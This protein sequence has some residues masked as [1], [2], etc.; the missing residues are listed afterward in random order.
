LGVRGTAEIKINNE[1]FE[2]VHSSL[3]SRHDIHQARIEAIQDDIIA[4][5]DT[6]PERMGASVNAW[7]KETR[8]EE[9]RWKPV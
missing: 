4:Q 8:P 3:V 9:K 2:V 6:H 1:K 5:R 7:R